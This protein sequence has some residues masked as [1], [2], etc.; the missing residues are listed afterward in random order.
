[1]TTQYWTTFALSLDSYIR[2]QSR[3]RALLT[4]VKEF[5]EPAVGVQVSDTLHLDILAL[6]TIIAIQTTLLLIVPILSQN[7]R[8]PS[9]RKALIFLS[10]FL[11][12][13]F[14]IGIIHIN[15]RF[16]VVQVL[17]ALLAGI[18][19]AMSLKWKRMS[20]GG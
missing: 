7:A 15:Y 6:M 4:P 19:F 2:L 17:V 16:P 5:T 1:M 10:G 8:S 14:T 13:A 20:T 3:E 11:G 9:I 18:C 12:L